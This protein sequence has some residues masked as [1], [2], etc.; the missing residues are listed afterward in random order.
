[1]YAW[2]F[3][4]LSLCSTLSNNNDNKYGK[5][6]PMQSSA[7]RFDYSDGADENNGQLV[8]FS[9][10]SVLI[11][12]WRMRGSLLEVCSVVFAR[13]WTQILSH[14]VTRMNVTTTWGLGDGEVFPIVFLMVECSRM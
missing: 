2:V 11:R 1:M 4:P 9:I 10:T 13:F 14:D 5:E 8:E 6:Q 7:I 12:P 3:R